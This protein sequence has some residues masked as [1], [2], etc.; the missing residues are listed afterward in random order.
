MPRKRRVA[1]V[2]GEGVNVQPLNHWYTGLAERSCESVWDGGRG[3]G[4]RGGVAARGEGV[5]GSGLRYSRFLESD[6][7]EVGHVCSGKAWLVDSVCYWI[8]GDLA[9]IIRQAVL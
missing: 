6:A 1:C 5:A 7:V 3:S 4:W 8:N 9:A 2:F